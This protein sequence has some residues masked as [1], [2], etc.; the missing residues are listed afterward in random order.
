MGFFFSVTFF[1]DFPLN[2]VST[3]LFLC[4]S[5]GTHRAA[6][7]GTRTSNAHA[8]G[9]RDEADGGRPG[10]HRKEVHRGRDRDG[11]PLT[12]GSHLSVRKNQAEIV[13]GLILGRDY[14]NVTAKKILWFFL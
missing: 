13:L 1:I 6:V 11:N 7:F 14:S 8:V 2:F 10:W 4:W 12:G 5:S 9:E 3:A